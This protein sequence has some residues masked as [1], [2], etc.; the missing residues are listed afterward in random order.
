MTL[1]D[2]KTI[3][4]TEA[5]VTKYSS[6]TGLVAKKDNNKKTMIKKSWQSCQLF[7]L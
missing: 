3:H 1:V 2:S 7:L 5:E 4:Y 6:F